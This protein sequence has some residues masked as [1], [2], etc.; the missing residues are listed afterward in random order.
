MEDKPTK[1]AMQF[2]YVGIEISSSHDPDKDEK[3]AKGGRD[4]DIENNGEESKE[5]QSEKPRYQ[6]AMRNARYSEMEKAT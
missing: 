3:H 1:Q 6:R 2:R 4:E 5:R